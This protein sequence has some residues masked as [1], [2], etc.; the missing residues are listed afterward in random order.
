MND[1]I[2]KRRTRIYNGGIY[3]AGGIRQ[4]VPRDGGVARHLLPGANHHNHVSRPTLLHTRYQ[5]YAVTEEPADVVRHVEKAGAL[6]LKIGEAITKFNSAELSRVDVLSDTCSMWSKVRQ[7]M[8]R[9]KSLNTAGRNSSITAD[10][11]HS[12]SAAIS[13]NANYTAPSVK[14]TANNS[15]AAAHITNLRLF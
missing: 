12:H 4:A 15:S 7:L 13:T 10:V 14:A 6:A 5:I 8:G 11:M 2:R 3:S 9:S 1:A